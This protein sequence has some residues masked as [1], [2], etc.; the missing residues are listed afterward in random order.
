MTPF[1][2][3]V[4]ACF[5]AQYG[6]DLYRHKFVFPNRRAGVFFRK[7]LAEIAG[8]PL[9]SPAIVTIQELFASFSSYRPADK[10]EMLVI[11]YRQFLRI[12]GSKESF[13]DF[14]YWGEMLLNDFDEVDKYLVDAEQ[15]FRNVRDIRSLD[16]DLSH[17][18]ERQREAVR[19][20]WSDFLRNAEE[21]KAKRTFHETWEVLSELYVA[22]RDALHRKGVAYEGMIFREVA[23]R[24]AAKE[25]F[26]WQ[27]ESFIFV[28]LNLLTPAERRLMEYLKNIGM[29]DFYWDYAAPFLRD[30]HN[31]ASFGMTENLTRFPSKMSLSEDQDG[32]GKIAVE[33]I[34]VPSGVGQ[35][36][37]VTRI[38]SDLA[39]T[40]QVNDT[41]EAIDTAIVLPDENLLMPLLYSIPQEIRKIN[42]TM[43]YALSLAS[44]SGLVD[45]LAQLQLN[46]RSANGKTT[47]YHL[48]VLAL[49]NH[50][51]V[52]MIAPT[53]AG[54]LKKHIITHNRVVVTAEEIPHHPLLKR[55][56]SPVTVWRELFGYLKEIFA[57]LYNHLTGKKA[58]TEEAEGNTR[59]IDLEREFIVQY[60]QTVTRLHDMLEE[61]EEM[62]VATCFKLLEKLSYRINVAFSG[63]PLSGLQVMGVL[64]TRAV[65]F[66]N[67]IILSMNEGVFPAKNTLNSFIPYTL[68]KGF[69][70]PTFEY[71]DSLY[72][73]HFYRMI[74]RSKRIFLLYDT[75]AEGMQSGEMSRYI[76]QMKYLYRDAFHWRERVVTYDVSAPRQMPVAI[77]KTDAVMKRLSAFTDKGERGLSASLINNYIDCPLKF[78]FTAIEQL[79]EETEVQ[80]SVDAALFGSIFHRVMETV[81]NRHKQVTIT[82]DLLSGII[83]DEALLT[84]LLEEAFAH[85][86]FKDDSHPQPLQGPLFLIGEILRSYV[87]QTLEADKRFT[88]FEY[89]D[90]E[91]F[92][93]TVYRV[94]ELLKVRFKGFIDRIDRVNGSLRIIDYKT[95]SGSTLFKDIPQ[96]FDASQ[97]ERPY[98]ILQVLMY[99]L[100]YLQ[101]HPEVR[102]APALYY[103][104]SIFDR[105]DPAVRCGAHPVHDL[106]PYL[107]EF[108]SRFNTLLEEIFDPGIP[109]SQTTNDSLCSYCTFREVCRRT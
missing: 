68:R 70:L 6:N 93:S 7:Y 57:Y 64:E 19:R 100:F 17:L 101:Q 76:Y 74:G 12:S 69:G 15:L 109:F 55:I 46:R 99:G 16:D 63:E 44:V 38:L 65:D 51:L 31:R 62:T 20:F 56:F 36:K 86:Y 33:V 85:Y 41:G 13:D 34:G 43:G 73:Y 22:F 14:L 75:R 37:H 30:P 10:I 4:A 53:E 108:T 45:H 61:V 107:P 3:Q 84:R 18:N 96:L 103:L 1:L 50:P 83:R 94:N 59:S 67:L 26:E 5:Y 87:K 77:P 90:S 95:G 21:K 24:A 54:D 66:E 81:Y 39:T 23:E 105:F 89:V 60:Y 104:R 47:F 11:L 42:V 91:L 106:S 25:P 27:T 97:K 92:F 35:A 58:E 102:V 80:E 82:P 49:L 98:Q 28:G 72:A 8:K 52:G 71:Q 40:K 32:N 78:Y 2:Y 48:P 79:Q 88:P 9:F 29:A